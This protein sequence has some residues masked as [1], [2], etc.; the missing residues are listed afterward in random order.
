MKKIAALV[1]VLA[2]ILLF[3]WF[4]Q[5]DQVAVG[6]T[7][8]FSQTEPEER[9]E[10]FFTNRDLNELEAVVYPEYKALM[11]DLSGEG[12]LVRKSTQ[13]AFVGAKVNE[14]DRSWTGYFEK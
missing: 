10:D 1:V 8:E 7:T 2:A 11:D 3:F 6:P 5:K 14:E 12:D 9:M 13:K 4:D